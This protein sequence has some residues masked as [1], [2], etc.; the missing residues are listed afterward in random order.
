[1]KFKSPLTADLKAF[2]DGY[3]LHP[4][5]LLGPIIRDGLPVS[6]GSCGENTA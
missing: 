5:D 6:G 4:S 2:S 1:M 3:Q